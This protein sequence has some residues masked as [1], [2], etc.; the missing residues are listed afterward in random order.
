[1]LLVGLGIVRGTSTALEV[2]NTALKLL[3]CSPMLVL[4]NH[5]RWFASELVPVT[6]FLTIRNIDMMQSWK[7]RK[8]RGWCQLG[9]LGKLHNTVIHIRA[10]DYRYNL[11]R[12]RAGKVLGLDN[13]TRWNSWFLLLDAAL[14]KRRISSGIRTSTTTPLWTTT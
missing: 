12:R 1:V 7:R 6:D 3:A 9:P 13:D 5:L 10:N 2:F 4:L 11:F 8:E 14:D